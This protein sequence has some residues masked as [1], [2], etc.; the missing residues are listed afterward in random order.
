MP[1]LD[2]ARQIV[3]LCQALWNADDF[4]RFRRKASA[5]AAQFLAHMAEI[6]DPTQG[7]SWPAS[8]VRPKGNLTRGELYFLLALALLPLISVGLRILALPGILSPGL[9]GTLLPSIGHDLSRIL[10]LQGIPHTDL[11]R[12]LY[13]LFLPIGAILIALAR[14]TLGMR[15]IGFRS[16]LISVGF[17]Q[18]GIL[19]SLL[20]IVAMVIVVIV[21]RPALVSMRLDYF[22]R[23]AVL[24]CSSVLLLLCVLL[25]APLVN[26]EVL[27]GVAF[28]PVLVLGLLAEGIA[29]TIDQESSLSALWRTALT[30]GV[31][32]VLAAISQI[33]LL[34]E[35][36]IGFPELVLT[37]LVAIILIAE[38]LDLRLL[39]D[40]DAKLTGIDFPRLHS[41]AAALRVA[42]VRNYRING[43]IGPLG[44]PS[45]G[46][47]NR[48]TVRRISDSLR[49]GGHTVQVFEGDIELLA[50]LKNFMAPDPMTQQPGGIVLNLSHGIQGDTSAAHVPAM[51]ELAGLPYTGPAQR[52]L[53]VTMDRVVT[54]VLLRVAGISTPA[55]RVVGGL[56]DDYGGLT[57]PVVVKPRIAAR[58]KLRIARDRKQLDTILGVVAGGD[59]QGAIVEPYVEGREIEV[60]ILGNAVAE[61]LPLVEVLPNRQGKAC[62]AVL[63]SELE[64]AVRSAA[65]EAFRACACRDYAVINLRIS[66]FGEPL[67]LEVE[68]DGVLAEG[69]S[70]SI[71]AEAAGLTFP[72]LLTRI[73]NVARQ[74]YRVN[75]PISAG[76][77]LLTAGD[78]GEHK[79]RA[80]I[81]RS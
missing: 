72:D 61:C 3:G 78:V 7:T 35:I 23:V 8:W 39:Q 1:P 67:V 58:Y 52:G 56:K 45:T 31:A 36:A 68:V 13:L 15:L 40:W 9:S 55:A 74:R 50:K 49:K 80:L 73:I 65:I 41:E 53:I 66:P 71:A 10:S 51:L 75:V 48:R 17:Q 12:V 21:I 42:V 2:W 19:P 27:W 46:G 59:Q 32:L 62:P 25:L 70:F 29:K 33:P 69:E 34:R 28:F 14:L 24:M 76:G 22:A 18:S 57:Y 6:P 37:Q 63:G 77:P 81:A 11:H 60:A 44:P 16:I 64:N 5:R 43:V 79:G 47:Y 30:I 38:F 4:V 20:L 26:S 54:K